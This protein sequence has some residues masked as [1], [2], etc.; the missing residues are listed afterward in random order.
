MSKAQ[1][2]TKAM[3]G[4]VLRLLP[5]MAVVLIA[6]SIIGLA[7]PILPLHVN[8]DLGLGTFVVGLVTGSQFAASLVSRVWAGRYA[9]AHGAKRAVVI[10]L[11]TAVASGGLY[12]LS[13]HFRA[14]PALSV[15]VLIMGRALLGA[16]E[17]FIITGALGWGLALVDHRHA[18]KVIAWVGMAMFAAFALGAPAGNLLFDR[19]GF[20]SIA[21]ATTVVPLIALLVV[22]RVR[23]VNTQPKNPQGMSQVIGAV[24]VPGLGLAFSSIGFGAITAFIA[25]LFTEKGWSPLWLAFTAFAVAFI[26]A[27]VFFGHLPDKLGGA[28]V[29]FVFALIEAAGLILIWLAPVA[30]VAL[31]GALLT[32]AGYSL[33]FPGL[34]VEAV[35]RVPTQNRA[36]AMGTYTAFLDLALGITT[37]ALGL[38]ASWGTLGTVFLISAVLAL[39]CAGI[40]VQLI[41]R[42]ALVSS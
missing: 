18:G 42:S 5:I 34:G 3:S 7:L 33:V 16:A 13:L 12:L 1:T 10:G 8:Q 38:I 6:F 35:R 14:S 30:E 25:L 20:I 22:A 24:W 19:F 40:S 32:G 4:V 36:L 15:S 26:L 27:R 21:M 11:V 29:A 41:R 17:S 28:K 31:A 39:G 23:P 37:P 9:D 2:D